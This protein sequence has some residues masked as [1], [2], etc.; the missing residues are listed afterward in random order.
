[1]A[2]FWSVSDGQFDDAYGPSRRILYEDEP[3]KPTTNE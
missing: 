2:F 1:V 3:D